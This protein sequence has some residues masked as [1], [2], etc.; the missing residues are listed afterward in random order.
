MN[1]AYISDTIVKDVN[2]ACYRLRMIVGYANIMAALGKHGLQLSGWAP[3]QDA[4]RA[5]AINVCHH[6]D[7]EPYER[8]SRRR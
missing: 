2:Q 1:K 7:G 3:L 4:A 5:V 6:Q 8:F